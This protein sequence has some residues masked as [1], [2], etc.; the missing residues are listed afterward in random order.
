MVTGA[1]VFPRATGA[2]LEVR[3]TGTAAS[4]VEAVRKYS[5]DVVLVDFGLPDFNGV[6]AIRQIRTFSQTPVKMLT[7]HG[8]LADSPYDAGVNE[9]MAKPFSPLELRRRVEKLRANQRRPEDTTP[10]CSCPHPSN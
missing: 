10:R 6:E 2:G 5:P 1:P 4:G 7:G 8:E 3:T 9:L